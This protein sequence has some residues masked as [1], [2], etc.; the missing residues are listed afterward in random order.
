M[1]CSVGKEP[2]K[3]HLELKY[4]GRWTA[5]TGYLQSTMLIRY[6]F[7]LKYQARWTACTGYLQ[8]TIL[9]RYSFSLKYHA[10]WNTCTGYLQSTMLIRYPLSS[11]SNELLEMSRLMH[12]AAVG[13]LTGHTTLRAHKYKLG[14]RK[15]RMPTVWT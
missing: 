9:I 10:R 6:P 13:L 5:C 11:K 2:I 7:T 15:S 4:Q 8:S 1:P 14:H 12:R 3:R